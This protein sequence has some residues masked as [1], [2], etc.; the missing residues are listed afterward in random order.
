MLISK[1]TICGKKVWY[2]Q[3]QHEYNTITFY[4]Y[5]GLTHSKVNWH[6]YHIKCMETKE[7]KIN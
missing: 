1:C 2:W 3:R 7:N 4:S 6:Y 5:N